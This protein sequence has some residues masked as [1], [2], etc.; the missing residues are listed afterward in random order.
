MPSGA[1]LAGVRGAH[2]TAARL[3]LSCSIASV[4]ERAAPSVFECVLGRGVGFGLKR[5]VKNGDLPAVRPGRV[6]Q[7]QGC[8]PNIPSDDGLTCL[9]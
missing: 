7:W 8:V 4:R 2:R 9:V 6:Q 1:A 5:L 3:R